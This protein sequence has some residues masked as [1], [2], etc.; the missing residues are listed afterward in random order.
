MIKKLQYLTE[1]RGKVVAVVVPIN[2][3][4]AMLERICD[5]EAKLRPKTKLDRQLDAIFQKRSRKKKDLNLDDIGFLGTGRTIS[6]AESL[7]MS[8]HV[9]RTW[10]RHA[11]SP[12]K[13]TTSPA[14]KR[15]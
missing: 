3:W 13:V 4:I 5:L 9:Q 7:L 10:G 11:A 2:D 14:K 6:Q 8:A 15:R 1:P 12:G